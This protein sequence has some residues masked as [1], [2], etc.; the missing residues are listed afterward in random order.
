MS[1]EKT[2]KC[3]HCQ[4]DIPK[5][6]KICPVCKKKQGG[7]LK[8]V[9]IVIA[10]IVVIAIISAIMGEDSSTVPQN[11]ENATYVEDS[12]LSQVY[13][14]PNDFKG[15][16]AKISG[17]VFTVEEEDGTVYFQMWHD[18][19][20]S[21]DNTVVTMSSGD[22]KI[23]EGDYV[24][25]DGTIAGAFEGQNAFGGS[26]NAVAIEAKSVEKSDYKTVV[27]P[28]I[29]AYKTHSSVSQHGY[30]ITIQRV[31]FAE[32]E[33]RVYVVIENNGSSKFNFYSYNIKAIQGGKQYEEQENY[34]ADY[35]RP[36]T[37]VMTGAKTEG[38]IAFPAMND[39]KDIKIVCEGS[40]DDW[41]EEIAP[42][43]FNLKLSKASK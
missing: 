15:R 6:V 16:L 27:A 3:K 11:P 14:S 21:D 43:T 39:S 23:K 18:T 35:E 20:N 29:K 19:E 38:I 34:E 9:A 2:K 12:E 32:K 24:I 37:E 31:E 40:S 26:V 41:Q 1:E 36:Q 22:L 42:Y 5:K 17:K 8:W 30:S 7:K 13:S 28:T 4:S 25:V 10:V 33:T